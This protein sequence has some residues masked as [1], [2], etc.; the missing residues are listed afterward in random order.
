MRD[1]P[2][3]VGAES[4]TRREPEPATTRSKDRSSASTA[5]MRPA[6]T[7]IL[8]ASQIAQLFELMIGALELGRRDLGA[9]L[10]DAECSSYAG[11]RA[12]DRLPGSRCRCGGIATAQREVTAG[13]HTQS[14]RP[15]ATLWLRSD[16]PACPRRLRG[17]IWRNGQEPGRHYTGKVRT[18]SVESS[19]QAASLKG[20]DFGIGQSRASQLTYASIWPSSQ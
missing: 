8:T 14:I 7:N 1:F 4:T 6:P 17:L 9:G 2:K 11:N 12:S 3:P 13:Q 19:A 15:R 20:R 18:S 16:E 10:C 5:S